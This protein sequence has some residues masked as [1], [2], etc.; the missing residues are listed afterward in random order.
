[1]TETLL[2]NGTIVTQNADREIIDDGAVAVTGGR[3]TAVGTAD[4]LAA[5]T[6]PDRV[7]DAG[8]GAV[9]PGLINAHTHVSDIL[10]RGPFNADRGLYDWLFNVKQ[11]GLFAMDAGDH[12]L[13]A[14]LYCLE[15]IRSGTTTFVENDTAL[16]WADLGATRRK[17]DVY[18]AMGVRS[19][20]GA[21]IRD[22]YADAAFER[23]FGEIRSREPATPHPGPDALVVDTD[24]ALDGVESLIERYHDPGGRQSVWPA[25]ATVATTTADALR[26]SYRLAETHDVMTTAHVAEAEAERDARG[27]LSSVE[28]LRNAGYLGDRALLGHCVQTDRR[29]VRILAETGASVAH[30]YRANMRLAT[31]FAPVASMLERGVTVA[32]GTD[33]AILNDAVDPLADAG[34]AAAAHKG[35]N[36]DPGAFPAGHALDAVTC[37]AA[38]AIGRGDELGSIEV[39]AR[40]DLAVVD[41]DEPHLTPSPDPVHALVYGASGADVE[42][43]LCDGTVLLDGGELRAMDE[44]VSEFLETASAAATDIL[45]RARIR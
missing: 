4:R 30:N 26:G 35:F 39:G 3:I 9:I 5:D 15:A 24:D 14:R 13:A 22:R 11:P 20:Y 27:G 41:L 43:V 31:G 1:M 44:P 12:A 25:P 7:I 37:G 33:N 8:G 42:T 45:E 19:V 18:D 21:G 38:A 32:V 36:R 2:T 34:A 28:Y 23:L 6:S 16:R 40:A 10:L 17:L 29:D